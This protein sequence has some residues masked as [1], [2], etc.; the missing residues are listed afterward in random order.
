MELTKD[1]VLSA[2][3]KVEAATIRDVAIAAGNVTF[4]VAAEG[5]SVDH[6]RLGKEL[7]EA[8]R[9]LPGVASVEVRW[10]DD[11]GMRAIGVD[12]PMPGV[13]N[14]ILVMSGKGGVGKSTTAT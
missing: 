6:A 8:V 12:D 3:A 7:R 10:A 4:T 2:L 13:K 1:A 9:A 5:S 14:V 11:I